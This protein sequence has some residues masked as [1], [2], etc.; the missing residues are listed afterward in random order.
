VTLGR[1]ISG[2]RLQAAMRHSQRMAR[3]ET[4]YLP[5]SGNFNRQKGVGNV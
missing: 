5:Q 1:N 4:R 3:T 2:V